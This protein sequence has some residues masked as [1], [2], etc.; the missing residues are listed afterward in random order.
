MGM[1]GSLHDDRGVYA[2]VGSR[3]RALAG[4]PF[5]RCSHAARRVVAEMIAGDK[6]HALRGTV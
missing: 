3:W 5:R 6:G 1:A 4:L 2:E